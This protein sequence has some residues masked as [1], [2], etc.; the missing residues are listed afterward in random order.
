VVIIPPAQNP[1][2]NPKLSTKPAAWVQVVHRAETRNG[3]QR[4]AFDAHGRVDARVHRATV[5]QDGARAT[6]AGVA[7]LFHFKMDVLAEQCAQALT[8]PRLTFEVVP[9]HLKSHAAISRRISSS[10]TPL[11]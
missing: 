6:I 5:D 4:T 3:C 2:W 10:R 8:G 9:V 1:H 7:T 11:T